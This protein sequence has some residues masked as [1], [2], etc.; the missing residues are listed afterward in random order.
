MDYKNLVVELSD[1]IIT[2]T[3]NR[4]K[5]L[6]ALNKETMQELHHFFTVEARQNKSLKGIIITGAG[7]KSFVAGAEGHKD[8]CS[9]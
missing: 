5:A 9:L 6:N 2:L 1:D 4:E 3:I 8:W 7:P